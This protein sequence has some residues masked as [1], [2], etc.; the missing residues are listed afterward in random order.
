MKC[1]EVVGKGDLEVQW[2]GTCLG[3]GPNGFPKATSHLRPEGLRV[4]QLKKE[5]QGGRRINERDT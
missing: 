5:L 3:E 2:E 4:D 1:R